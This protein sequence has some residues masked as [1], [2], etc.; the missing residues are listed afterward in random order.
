MSHHHPYQAIKELPELVG[1]GPFPYSITDQVHLPAST[2]PGRYVLSWRW[3]AEQT[4]QVWSQC[5]EVTVVP[6]VS[7]SASEAIIMPAVKASHNN[8]NKQQHGV[9]NICTGASIG[10]DVGECNAWVSL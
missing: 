1:R 3:D 4:K 2:A 9:S 7:S 5:S 10:L 8:N 6:A